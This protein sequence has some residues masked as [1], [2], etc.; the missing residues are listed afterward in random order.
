MKT[1][2]AAL[3]CCLLAVVAT[4]G[5]ATAAHAAAPEARTTGVQGVTSGAATLIGTVDANNAETTYFFEYGKT[6]RYGSRT[7]DTSAGKG[8]T[9]QRVRA[10]VDGL[11]PDTTYHFR[12]VARNA[13]GVRS[14]AD[15]TFKTKKQPLGLQ[16]STAPN[17]VAFGNSTL[18]TGAL[19][20]TG[21]GNQRIQLQQRGFPFTANWADL[22]NPVV[23]DANGNFTI[24]VLPLPLTT[25]FRA[26]VVDKPNVLSEVITQAVAARVRTT[27][28]K[29]RVRR[30]KKVR[31]YGSVLPNRVGVPFE[32]QKKTKSGSWVVVRRGMTKESSDP[33]AARYS[34][35]VR[36]PRTALYRVLVNT[37]A[38]DV[39]AGFGPEFT[40]KVK[41]GS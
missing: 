32:I 4:L 30:N 39:I 8:N 7:P 21:N 24:A 9:R 12:V 15:R 40:V 13:D 29:K 16:I 14:G 2:S 17:P 22:G 41:K 25:Q 35:R 3:R 33:A 37:A 31:V 18:I 20:G 19:T 11:E 5:L 34:R 10:Q 6:R 38:G 36:V 1:M 23:T 27:T 26:R 28:N